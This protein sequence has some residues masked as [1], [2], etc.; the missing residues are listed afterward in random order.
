MSRPRPLCPFPR[1]VLRGALLLACGGLLLGA[2]GAE[3]PVE[4]GRPAPDFELPAL[5]GGT[6]GSGEL[7]GGPAVVT[8]WATWCQPCFREIPVLQEL[9]DSGRAEVVAIAL[10]EQGA[11]VVRPFVEERGIRYPVALGDQ[12]TFT[13]FDGFAIPY[14]LVL[15]GDRRIVAIHRGPA[16]TETLLRDVDRAAA[17]G[18]DGPAARDAEHGEAPQAERRTT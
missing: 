15:D 6:V 17:R 13:R 16:D 3:A 18:A 8:F 12:E 11:D 9:H 14:T 2:C 4:V 7:A 1:A 5:D 10:D